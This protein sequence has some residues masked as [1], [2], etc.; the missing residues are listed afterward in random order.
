MTNV[1]VQLVGDQAVLPRAELDLLIELARRSEEVELH[2]QADD[3]P[4]VGLARLAERGGVFDWLADEPDLYTL[5]DLRVR[6][7]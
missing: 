2:D 4:N 7:R 5:D 6:Y 3:L 1:H